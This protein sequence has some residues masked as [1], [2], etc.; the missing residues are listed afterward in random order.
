M[1]D[2]KDRLAKLRQAAIAK[3]AT[4]DLVT[5]QEEP[6]E[7]PAPAPPAAAKKPLKK[8]KEVTPEPVQKVAQKAPTVKV[9]RSKGGKS[10]LYRLVK[11]DSPYLTKLLAADCATHNAAVAKA[12]KMAGQK[13]I[14]FD[15]MVANI[16]KTGWK[17]T[18]GNPAGILRWHLG[19][20][21]FRHQLVERIS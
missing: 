2:I 3:A 8:A 5:T 9:T 12:L 11:S 21:E 10:A 13:G 6:A 18:S 4:P 17:T 19:C 1:S 15:N 14:T 16:Q 20:L 7:D